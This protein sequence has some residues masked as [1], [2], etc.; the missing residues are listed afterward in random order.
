MMWI[1]GFFVILPVI[2]LVM[3]INADYGSSGVTW[4][5]ILCCI[6]SISNMMTILIT[7]GFRKELFDIWMEYSLQG[8]EARKY[9]TN[10]LS[11]P[12]NFGF[13]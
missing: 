13:V 12:P 1:V 6:T 2:S 5:F 7:N 10:H 8:S 4:N 9:S 11:L 3:I